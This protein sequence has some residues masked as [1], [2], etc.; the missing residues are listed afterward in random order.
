MPMRQGF[1][2][3]PTLL[4]ALIAVASIR[5][6][7]PEGFVFQSGVDLVRVTTTV[8]DPGGRFV[9]GLSKEDFVVYEDGVRQEISQFSSDRAPV[10]LG[11][12]LDVSGSMTDDKMDAARAA[13]DRFIF[14]LLDEDDELF[15][16]EFATA[17]ALRQDWTRD[18]RLISR[19]VGAARARGDTA[20]Y[21]AIA[22]A[23]PKAESGM[24]RKKALLVISDGNDSHSTTTIEQLRESIRDS[25]VLVYALGIDSVARDDAPARP[26]R[27]P[28]PAPF[29]VPGGRARIPGIELPRFPP[30]MTPPIASTFPGGGDERVNADAL[31]RITD[32][33]GGLTAIVRGPAG[34]GP[35]TAR[36]A[37][38][39]SR[40]YDL[41]YASNRER[42]RKWH[43]IRVEV[44]KRRVIVR[45]RTGY[46]AS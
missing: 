11:I 23:I 46:Y 2:A 45:A 44:P 4:A 32:D 39:L 12:L 28:V 16:V 37:D 7:Q 31:R 25:E 41:A 13:I 10:S 29:P 22:T 36:I 1:S 5:A 3:L 26:P 14:E 35:A 27:I 42:D 43:V 9:T 21:D 8:T 6:Q 19:A 34:L 24:H 40:Q 33:T 17:T 30:P 20:L 38:E 18:R 15:F